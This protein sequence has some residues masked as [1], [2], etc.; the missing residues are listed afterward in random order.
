MQPSHVKK[1]ASVLFITLVLGA[2]VALP[3]A[4][5]GKGERIFSHLD[6]NNNDLIEAEEIAEARSRLFARLDKDDDGLVP[7]AEM[8]KKFQRM[9]SRFPNFPD[10][11][12]M[13][14]DGDELVSEAE[15]LAAPSLITIADTDA[16]GDISRT[17]LSQ[18]RKNK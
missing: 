1:P 5:Q 7:M 18:L 12:N 15:F 11:K 3:A 14:S 4:A 16:S 10:P 9:Q 17:E 13:D 2:L 8:E 6:S